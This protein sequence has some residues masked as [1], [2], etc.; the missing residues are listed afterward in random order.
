MS[1][2]TTLQPDEQVIEQPEVIEQPVERTEPQTR[3]EM[4]A[5]ALTSAET[6]PQERTAEQRARDEA[7]RFQKVEKPVATSAPISAPVADV[8]SA[9]TIPQELTTW[10]KEFRPLYEKLG[11][12]QPLTPEESTKLRGYI[13]QREA[14]ASTGIS[15]YKERAQRLE[16]LEKSITPF[17]PNLQRFNID[18]SK[19]L[20]DLGTAH[21]TLALGTPQQKLAMFQQ[22]AKAYGIPLGAVQQQEEGGQP[23]P[24]Y[25]QLMERIDQLNGKVQDVA[26]WK[27]KQDSERVANSIAEIANDAE[28]YPHFEKVRGTMAQL[29]ESGLA[30]DLKTAY[31]KAVR[32]DDEVWTE[33]QARL[34]QASQAQ[35]T[36]RQAVAK[37]KAAAISPRSATPSGAVTNAGPKDRRQILSEQM[38]AISGRV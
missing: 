33:E 24:V 27:E 28:K 31:A 12:G 13:A 2:Q 5:E 29:L 38:D 10:K 32:M 4:L 15:V 14:E 3:R 9:V 6:Q 37:A 25:L 21:E 30:P 7:G 18:P 8:A 11:S 17:M 26:G 1:E 34:S 23:D 22:L 36:Q 35:N 16:G 20:N 19:W